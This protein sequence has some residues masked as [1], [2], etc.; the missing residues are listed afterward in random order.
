MSAL[1]KAVDKLNKKLK[2]EGDDLDMGEAMMSFGNL[3]YKDFVKE[4]K[5]LSLKIHPDKL[6]VGSKYHPKLYSYVN[7]WKDRDIAYDEVIIEDEDEEDEED[8][9][10]NDNER[11]KD[12]KDIVD[13]FED[14]YNQVADLTNDNKFISA[15]KG[16]LS[17]NKFEILI[18]KKGVLDTIQM[19]Y[20]MYIERYYDFFKKD[21][22]NFKKK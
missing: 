16:K 10:T 14:L 1:Q 18:K 13:D 3:R 5:K 4:Y 2:K 8:K 11:K 6:E 21:G 19:L 20:D 15:I 7:N 17:P 22:F 9:Y 12:L